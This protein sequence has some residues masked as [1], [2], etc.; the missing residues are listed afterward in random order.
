LGCKFCSGVVIYIL[1]I[2]LTIL[3]FSLQKHSLSPPS[4]W[5]YQLG[6]SNV[7]NARHFNQHVSS[8]TLQYGR[9]TTMK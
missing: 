4:H 8:S 3:Q 9:Q 6:S 7:V 2:T 5:R 1:I